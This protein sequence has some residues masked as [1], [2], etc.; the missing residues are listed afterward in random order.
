MLNL[1]ATFFEHIDYS[2]AKVCDRSNNSLSIVLKIF[3]KTDISKYLHSEQLVKKEFFFFG[4]KKDSY[5]ILL[6]YQ[7]MSYMLMNTEWSKINMVDNTIYF[8]KE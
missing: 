4:P 1:T 5:I 6:N 7:K 3:L 8:L 2:D